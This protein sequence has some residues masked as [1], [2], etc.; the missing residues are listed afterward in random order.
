MAPPAISIDRFGHHF[1]FDF[2]LA[3]DFD[4]F[5]LRRER[6]W[7]EVRRGLLWWRERVLA[8]PRVV[9]LAG[10]P[11]YAFGKGSV[12]GIIGNLT[13]AGIS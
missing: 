13:E 4:R 6:R 7:G 3:R 11:Y 8:H 5:S 2:P 12:F 9:F 1:I 10:N